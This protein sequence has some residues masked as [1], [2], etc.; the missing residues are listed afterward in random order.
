MRKET[1]RVCFPIIL[2]VISLSKAF[3]FDIDCP[4]GLRCAFTVPEFSSGVLAIPAHQFVMIN[5]KLF[6]EQV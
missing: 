3:S 5:P 6:R 4:V 1:A 2:E